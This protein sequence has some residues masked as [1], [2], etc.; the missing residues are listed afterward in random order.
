MKRRLLLAGSLIVPCTIAKAIQQVEK[1]SNGSFGLSKTR[2]RK[3][4][5]AIVP[6]GGAS[7]AVSTDDELIECE[8]AM[9]ASQ[10]KSDQLDGVSIVG[11][12]HDAIDNGGSDV[13]S[14][15]FEPVC[16]TSR[17][18][19]DFLV[20]LNDSDSHFESLELR[21]LF[22]NRI[23]DFL[24]ELETDPKSAGTPNDRL[25]QYFAPKIPAIKHMPQISLR[26]QS[27]RSDMDP[28]VAAALIGAL[29]HA[30]E[31]FDRWDR[32]QEVGEKEE[33]RR[34][35]RKRGFRVSLDDNNIVRERRF[36][37]LVE[38]M[39]CGLDT[40]LSRETLAQEGPEA[41][42]LQV[43]DLLDNEDVRS[44]STQAGLS[45]RDACRG[46]W[47]L[48]VLG[49][50]RNKSIGEVEVCDVFSSLANRVQLL[51]LA[52]LEALRK[53]E[54]LLRKQSPEF[55]KISVDERI[56][57]M[58]KEIAEEASIALWAFGCVY[59]CTGLLYSRL[60]EVCI[61]ILS[62]NPIELRRKAQDPLNVESTG[63]GTSDVVNR[64]E[65]AETEVSAEET[66]DIT[67]EGSCYI[68]E[69]V[70]LCRLSPQEVI[71]VMWSLALYDRGDK[72]G[73]NLSG[74]TSFFV[75]QAFDYFIHILHVESQRIIDI[76]LV[77][78]VDETLTD[79]SDTASF[80]R[81][82]AEQQHANNSSVQS[83][84]ENP[85][86]S[87]ERKI[88]DVSS[89]EEI[90]VVS[91]SELLQKDAAV[92]DKETME[93]FCAEDDEPKL[94]IETLVRS[95]LQDMSTHDLCSIA[96]IVTE[97]RDSRCST[98]VRH[99]A[100]IFLALGKESV[101]S[102]DSSDLANL[103]WALARS[104][105]RKEKHT[106]TPLLEWISESALACMEGAEA[107]PQ[108]SDLLLFHFQPPELSRLLWSIATFLDP[109]LLVSQGAPK[110]LSALALRAAVA[111]R[112]VF[113]T[114]DLVRKRVSEQTIFCLKSCS[115]IVLGSYFVGI[116]GSSSL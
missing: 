94:R 9:S 104:E 3:H 66:N 54:L 59:A 26:V 57:S 111:N 23:S 25:L 67:Q 69:C 77:N 71:D 64:L 27:G 87:R 11:A 15:N 83:A 88:L 22:M 98:V 29:A 116:P 101:Y 89:M 7:T 61:Y 32:H 91:A 90:E 84:E 43:Q 53:G 92:V 47:G 81:R 20:N 103:A 1:L 106:Y 80:Q 51:L 108:A 58:G 55:S 5:A 40:T 109:S 95:G 105:L 44:A 96:W 28:G 60:T 99:L 73:E 63:I 70:L 45:I 46:A 41:Q 82:R 114:E 4:F 14:E 97:L 72:D 49:V 21:K 38:C 56:S 2:R 76:Q 24:E 115:F 86:Q 39:L 75:E 74:T 13:M 33:T 50:H 37:Q 42:P 16:R 10:E 35:R 100:D 62:Q 31:V 8:E 110:D 17:S 102:L 78:N 113:G 93:T 12:S 65:M 112:S 85:S 79:V 52:R 30:Q 18:A 107:T 68:E 48:A 19:S 36:E 34:K 6:H